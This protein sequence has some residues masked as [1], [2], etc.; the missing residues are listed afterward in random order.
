MVK[1]I[2]MVEQQIP[3]DLLLK[4]RPLLQNVYSNGLPF[5][6]MPTAISVQGPVLPLEMLR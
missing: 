3:A 6:A 1:T 5:K 4:A 2:S